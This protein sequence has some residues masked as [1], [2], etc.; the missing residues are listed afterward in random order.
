MGSPLLVPV[1]MQKR[2]GFGI[3]VVRVKEVESVM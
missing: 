2:S 3:F 1:G